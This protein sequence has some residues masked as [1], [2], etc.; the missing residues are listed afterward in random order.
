M[1]VLMYGRIQNPLIGL[2]RERLYKLSDDFCSKQGFEEKQDV[3]RRAALLAQNPNE[4]ENLPELTED[5]KYWVRR[6]FTSA[7]VR[8][9]AC[10]WIANVATRQVEPN[11]EPVLL[12]HCLFD[13]LSYSR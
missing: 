11:L 3:F 6:E 2:S 13:R 4:Y 8:P 10:R 7:A 5:D 9:R 12:D 1:T